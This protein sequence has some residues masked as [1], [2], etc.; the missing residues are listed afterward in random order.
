MNFEERKKEKNQPER[1]FFNVIK[2]RGGNSEKRGRTGL[3]VPNMSK[4][5]SQCFIPTCL[6]KFI[7]NFAVWENFA[8]ECH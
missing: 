2:L 7:S 6:R 8:P 3:M 5:R 1:Y 4:L